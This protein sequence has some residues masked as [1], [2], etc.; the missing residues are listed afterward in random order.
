MAARRKKLNLNLDV[1]HRTNHMSQQALL[2]RATGHVWVQ[3]ASSRAH[4]IKLLQLGL[5]EF[6]RYCQNGCGSTWRQVW[7]L[8]ERC[9]VENDRRYP[10]KGEYLMPAG[11]GRLH[12][13]DAIVAEVAREFAGMM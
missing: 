12:R 4:T 8:R 3:R 13:A 9:I 2:C 10:A 7:S 11:S 6:D 1:D 5:R